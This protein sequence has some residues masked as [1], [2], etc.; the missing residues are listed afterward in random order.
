MI[1]ETNPGS[2]VELKTNEDNT[3]MYLFM[4][5]HASIK[6]WQHCL[7]VIVIDGTFL[8]SKFGG[9][10]L[11]AATQDAVGKIFPLAFIVADSENDQSWKWFF[12]QLKKHLG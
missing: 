11:I 10:V 8:K 4:A 12:I 7:P 1:Q 5:L 3:F 2:I 9:T 6:G